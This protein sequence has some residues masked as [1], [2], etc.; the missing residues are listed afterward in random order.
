MI[1]RTWRTRRHSRRRRSE[2]RVGSQGPAI[3]PVAREK[4]APHRRAS[5][6]SEYLIETCISNTGIRLSNLS[7]GTLNALAEWMKLAMAEV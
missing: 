3:E 1:P 5:L 4:S 7:A 6:D 2:P